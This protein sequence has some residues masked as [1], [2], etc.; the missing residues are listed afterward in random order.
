MAL[1]PC[2]REDL[3]DQEEDAD[4]RVLHDARDDLVHGLRSGVADLEQGLGPVRYRLGLGVLHVGDRE[5]E[6]AGEEDDR[7]TSVLT[8]D[9]TGLVGTMLRMIWARGG[10]A[11]ALPAAP[12]APTMPMPMPGRRMLA[13]MRPMSTARAEVNR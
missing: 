11:A 9:S 10:L 5:A 1:A 13:K 2:L 3:G 7:R 8:R 4:G 6:D 12:L